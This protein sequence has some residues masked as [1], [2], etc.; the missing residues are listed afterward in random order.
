MSKDDHLRLNSLKAWTQYFTK[1]TREHLIFSVV[2]MDEL[3]QLVTTMQDVIHNFFNWPTLVDSKIVVI[4][5][6]NTMD[7]PSEESI[8]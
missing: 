7:L 1:G 5:A 3:D 8:G 2:L 6:A 4:A